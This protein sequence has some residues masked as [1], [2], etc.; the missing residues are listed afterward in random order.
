MYTSLKFYVLF[1]FGLCLSLSG[2]CQSDNQKDAENLREVLKIFFNPVE[3][4]NQF[5]IDHKK[6]IGLGR[7]LFYDERLSD[8]STVS[9]HSCHNLNAFGTNGNYYLEQK[10]K[11][12][13]FRDVPTLYNVSTLP[14]YNADGGIDSIKEKLKHAF[15]NPFEMNIKDA[16]LMVEKLKEIDDYQTLF[17]EVYTTDGNAI[18][19]KN[20]IDAL[21]TFINGLTTPAPIDT[22]IKG[23]NDALSKEQIEG[24]HLFN[25][26]S[27]YSCHTG[28]NVGGQMIQKLGIEVAW[29]N[30]NDLGYYHL[31]RRSDYKMFFRVAPL[32]NVEKTAPYFHD[33]S[34]EKLWKAVELMGKHERGL[35]I[36]TADALKI[37]EF[38]KALTGE[39]PIDYIKQPNI[40][41]N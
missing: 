33:G 29:P 16:N 41:V 7:Y 30:Q 2:F 5:L 22:F 31:N 40:L 25:D 18:S 36:S 38:L 28:S 39:I 14:I 34:S 6:K 27:C 24:G 20:I 23:K 17:D 15:S 19:F 3:K 9:C 37:G 10:K 35:E 11:G 12:E 8:N 4:D 21:Q 13:S 1:Y 26:K 32:R